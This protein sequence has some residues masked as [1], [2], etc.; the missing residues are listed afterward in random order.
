M[1]DLKNYE[2]VW[3]TPV[4]VDLGSDNVLYSMGP[5]ASGAILAYILNILKYFNIKSGDETPLMFHRVAEAFKWA[6]AQRSKLGDPFDTDI[7]DLVNEL[8]KNMTSDE[9]ARQTYLK[10]NDTFTVNDPNYYGGDFW[11]PN[12]SGTSHT[13]ILAPNGDAVSVT[14]TVNL[15]LGARIL[16]PSTGIIYNDEMDDFSYPNITNDFAVPPSPHNFLKPGKR[17]LSSMTPV[18]VINKQ[19]GNVRIVTG[20]A[21]GSRITTST[22]LVVLRNLWLGQ[23]IKSAID[24]RRIHHQLLPMTV[25]CEAGLEQEI[26]DGLKLRGHQIVEKSGTQ[27]VVTGISVEADGFIYANADER[28]AGGIAGF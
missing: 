28:K 25:D 1:E 18:I 10:I 7:T 16:S 15:H 22:S 19:T 20:A 17:P 8:V 2:V 14:S 3:Q 5:P 6:Y 12:D 24:E 9:F 23:D 26:I 27:S 4:S 21:G 13:S 11:N